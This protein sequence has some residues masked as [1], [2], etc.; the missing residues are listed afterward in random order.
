MA[1]DQAA[2]M[3]TD[4]PYC[5]DYTGAN[6]PQDSGKDWSNKIAKSRSRIWASSCAACFLR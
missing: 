2:L 3:A 1:G 5:V 4:P 6:R